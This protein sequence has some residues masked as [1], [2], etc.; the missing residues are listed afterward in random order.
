[1][2]TLP[3]RTDDT[4]SSMSTRSGQRVTVMGL[5][6]FGGG[7]GVAAWLAQQGAD[8]LITDRATREELAQPLEALQ[9]AAPQA[10]FRFTLGRHDPQDFTTCDC[11]IVNPAVPRPW[12]NP[13]VLAA[14]QARIPITTEI[15]LTI[16]Q[17]A[18]RKRVIGITGTVGKS[19]TSAMIAHAL[20]TTPHGATLGGNIGGSLLNQLSQPG[21]LGHA[22]PDHW[23]VLEL[24]S[25]MLWWI[26]NSAQLYRPDLAVA[27]QPGNWAPGIAVI[28]TFAPNHLDW[29]P[30]AKHYEAAK[31]S[32]LDHQSPGDHAIFGPDAPHWPTAQGV[33]STRC[34]LPHRITDL[35]IPGEH[36]LANAATALQ[37]VL[38]AGMPEPAAI[39][40]LRTFGGLPH[41]LQRVGR[42]SMGSR[43]V[44]AFNDSK[45]TTPEATVRAVD[46]VAQYGP[47]RLIAGGYDKQISLDAINTLPLA[48]LYAIGATAQALR[49]HQCHTLEQAVSRALADSND[50]DVVLLSPGCASWD[51]FTHYEQRGQRFIDLLRAS[52]QRVEL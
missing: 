16:E 33:L 6:R 23:I 32:L 2:H 31:R 27:N 11:V 10:R 47:V 4:V 48:G 9:H 7:V 30:D 19:T 28:T 40:A 52:S 15:Q 51:Q 37:A 26:N 12:E 35:A 14:A 44:L 29:H 36:N 24:S 45:S 39:D 22:H 34:T 41:R 20:A 17:L 50:G 49:G 3:V 46:A 18:D 25:A 42:C 1:M 13:F 38:A 43:S 8:V 5:G 21:Q